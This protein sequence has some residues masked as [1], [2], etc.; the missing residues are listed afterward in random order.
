MF[1]FATSIIVS[2]IITGSMAERARLG[3]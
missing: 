1:Y 3:P 2:L